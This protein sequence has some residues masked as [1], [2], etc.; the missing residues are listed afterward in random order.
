MV[1]FR[2]N[3]LNPQLNFEATFLL[4][5]MMSCEFPIMSGKTT[6]FPNPPIYHLGKSSYFTKPVPSTSPV[7]CHGSRSCWLRYNWPSVVK[8]SLPSWSSDLGSFSFDGP[9]MAPFCRCFFSGTFVHSAASKEQS[10]CKNLATVQSS[11]WL[12]IW[13]NEKKALL[14]S[15]NW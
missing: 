8:G 12:I 15:C 5:P 10:L 6:I 11:D 9:R 1:N 14:I 2:V 4:R 3:H 13:H 7:C